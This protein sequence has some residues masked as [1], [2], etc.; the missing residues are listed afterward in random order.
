[1]VLITCPSESYGGSLMRLSYRICIRCGFIL[2]SITRPPLEIAVESIVT[3]AFRAVAKT[4][5][6]F[7]YRN[8]A[9]CIVQLISFLFS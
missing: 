5:G 3:G 9:I 7:A 8:L 2:Y 4:F 1:M 6:E